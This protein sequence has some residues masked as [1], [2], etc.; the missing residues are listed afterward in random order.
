[1]RV[2]FTE[3][4]PLAALLTSRTIEGTVPSIYLNRKVMYLRVLEQ[5]KAQNCQSGYE[6]KNGNCRDINECTQAG[7]EVNVNQNICKVTTWTS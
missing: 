6:L 4:L 2:K 1:M 5:G 7:T 3:I